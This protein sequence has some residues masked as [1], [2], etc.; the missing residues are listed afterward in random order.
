PYLPPTPGGG[1][2]VD[3]PTL[4]MGEHQCVV[5]QIRYAGT[6]IPDGANPFTSD[7]LSQRNLAFSAIANPGL[8]ASR[9]AVHTFEIEATPNAIGD[10]SLPD[11]LLLEWHREPPEGT[12]VQLEISSWEG[13][14]VVDLAD[15]FYARHEIRALGT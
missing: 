11:E 6:P 12:E 10:G 5:A 7:K 9:M 2:S 15:R 14:A 1:S 8:G 3:L 4:M 13:R